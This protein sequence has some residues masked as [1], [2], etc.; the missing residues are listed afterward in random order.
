V[1]GSPPSAVSR[2]WL[3]VWPLLFGAA[4]GGPQSLGDERAKCFRDDDCAPGLICVAPPMDPVNRV[5]SSDPTPLISN[6]E[7]PP[8]AV[9]GDAALAG[10]AGSAVA[11]GG[12][13]AVAGGGAGGMMPTAGTDTGGT[14]TAGTDAGGTDPGGSD[15]GGTQM[16]G[17]SGSNAG[18]E[19]GGTATG[20]TAGTGGTLAG[21]GGSV[22][23]GGAS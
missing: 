7:R 12:A 3:P 14:T 18:T 15:A 19:T 23:D 8:V 21:S 10:S 11:G 20:G 9:G 4:C 2:R 22:S 1:K 16:G 5:C 17:S 6:V 13:A